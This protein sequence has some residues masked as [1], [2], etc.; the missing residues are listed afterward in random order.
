MRVVT[1]R[2]K[3][4]VLFDIT[5]EYFCRETLNISALFLGQTYRI[6]SHQERPAIEELYGRM[7]PKI[8]VSCHGIGQLDPSLVTT[9]K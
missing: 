3:R 8:S 4:A 1:V 6:H 5:G 2:S 7:T 9:G